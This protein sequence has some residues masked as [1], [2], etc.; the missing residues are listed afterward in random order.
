[1]AEKLYRMGSEMTIPDNE[2][3]VIEGRAIVYDTPTVLYRDGDTEYKE[4]IA[5]GA[6][7]GADMK[8]CCL[9]YNHS[10]TALI[11]ARCRGGSLVLN[12]TAM[13]LD[14][15]A[16]MFDTQF[17]RDCKELVKNGALQCSFAFTV[18]EE[19]YDRQTHMRTIKKIDKLFD[20]SIVSDPAYS[21][22]Y[23]SARS[24][25]FFERENRREND[26]RIRRLLI[27]KTYL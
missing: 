2:G 25:E 27:A 23:V 17:A 7:E 16:N 1:M 15:R 12:D 13:G 9:K 4:Q 6:L 18:K 20:V 24:R 26:E 22:T 11:L 8:D 10:D 21:D 14:F 19:S 5:R 3:L